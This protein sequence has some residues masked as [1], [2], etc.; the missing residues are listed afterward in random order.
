[1]RVVRSA[2]EQIMD[3][4]DLNLCRS[5]RVRSLHSLLQIRLS[6]LAARGGARR[7]KWALPDLNRRSLRYERS[8]L[9]QTKL[10]ALPIKRYLLVPL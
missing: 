10:K 2:L 4:P 3:L 9:S 5:A 8:A 6:S 7:E 1:M